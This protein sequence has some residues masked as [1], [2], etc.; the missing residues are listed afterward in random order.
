MRVDEP[1]GSQRLV[2]TRTA[3]TCHHRFCRGC[4]A[5]GA[6]SARKCAIC[7]TMSVSAIPLSEPTPRL[8]VSAE[9]PPNTAVAAAGSTSSPLRWLSQS[10]V[11]DKSADGE[12]PPPS[13]AC[14]QSL[15]GR[16]AATAEHAP[17]TAMA[18]AAVA[19]V[20]DCAEP[21][22]EGPMDEVKS[23]TFTDSEELAKWLKWRGVDTSRWGQDMAKSVKS[24]FQEVESKNSVLLYENGQ[25]FRILKVLKV[26]VRQSASS[27]CHLVCYQ[28]KM[29]DGRMRERNVLPSMKVKDS[30][31][32]EHAVHRAIKK[33]FGSQRFLHKEKA[34]VV[35][36]EAPPAAQS[37]W[38]PVK[39]SAAAAAAA[40]RDVSVVNNSLVAWE[41]IIDSP[42][43]PSL[44]TQYTLMQMTAI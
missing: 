16:A 43:Y 8:D 37:K 1:R 10:D 26:V 20:E 24:L 44:S 17:S 7:G 19:Q 38:K 11:R 39:A 35:D 13:R 36:E 21:D 5:R 22:P 27:R 4:F 15:A 41:E 2:H 14:L 18:E 40:E 31:S 6:G 33:E 9:A 23:G 12:T 3:I 28:Q 30:D 42:S 25:V 34:A 32:P 29:N